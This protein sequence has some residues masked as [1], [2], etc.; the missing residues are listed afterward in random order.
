M[1]RGFTLSAA[2]LCAAA[3]AGQDRDARWRQDLQH[4]ATELPAR[5]INLR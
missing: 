4:L 2:L 5:H 1:F 3:L